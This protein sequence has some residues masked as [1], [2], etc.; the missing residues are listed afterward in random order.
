[1]SPL[2]RKLREYIKQKD[3]EL[4][5]IADSFWRI[6][7]PIHERQNRP[8]SN[9]NGAVHMAAVEDNIWRLL[10]T[11]TTENQANN[12]ESFSDFELFLL[13]CAACCHDF[14]KALKSALPKTLGFIHGEGSGDFVVENLEKLGLSEPQARAIQR[15][16]SIHDLK[17]VDFK[18]ELKKLSEKMASPYKPYNLQRLAV[19]LKAADIL[20]CDNSRISPLVLDA[21]K[22]EGMERKKYLARYCTHGWVSNGSRVEIQAEPRNLEEDDAVRECFNFMNENEWSAVTDEMRHYHFP[23]Q[24]KLHIPDEQRLLQEYLTSLV[25]ETQRIDMKGIYSRTGA[26]REAIHFPIEEIYTPLKTHKPS[27]EKEPRRDFGAM[28]E[29]KDE[30]VPLTDLLSDHRRLLIIGEPGGGKTTF[31]KFIA[32]VLAKDVL[33][34]TE[35]GRKQ[36][37]GMSLSMPPPVP[38]FMRLASLAEV[39]KESS[40]NVGGGAS[41]RCIEKAMEHIWGRGLVE[42]LQGP[43]SEGRCALLLDGLD[44][45]ADE[46]LRNQIVDVVNSTLEHWGENL[47]VLSSRPFGY[48]AVAGLEQMFMA[49]MDSFGEREILDFLD[50]WK[51]GLYQDSKDKKGIEYLNELRKAIMHSSSIRK[52]AHNPVMLTCLC[53]VHWNERK[54]PEGKAD[55][56]AAVLRW[57]L[58]ANEDKRKERGYTNTFA[59]E[60]FKVL[61]LAMTHHKEG[62]Q[63]I[64]DLAWAAD[65]LRKPFD[66]ILR[67]QDKDLVQRQGR[68][69]LEEEMLDSG[70]VEKQGVGQIRFWHLNFQEHFTARALVDRR[71]EDW[72]EIIEKKLYDRQ[73]TEVIDHFSGCLA[74]TGMYR[75]N[76]LVKKILDTRKQD[77][78]E[79]VARVVGVLGRILR[80]LAVYDNYQPPLS[81][82]WEDARNQVMEIFEI[83]GAQKVPVEQRI[84]AAEALGQGGDPRIDE[85]N[86]T[87]LPI[88]GMHDTLL[89]RYPVTVAEYRDFVDTGGYHN[90]LYWKEG[91][92]DRRKKEGWEAP[93]SWDDQLEYLN[94][95]VTRVSWYEAV[96]YCNWRTD[97]ISE[98]AVTPFRLPTS[99][100]WEKAVTNSNGAY[101]WGSEEPGPEL[102]NFNG[103][104]GV[105]TPVGI[106]PTGEAPG[107]HLDMAGNVWEWN[108][109][110]YSGRGSARVV[111]GGSWYDGAGFCRSAIRYGLDPDRRSPYVGFRLSRSVTL[112]P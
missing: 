77:E 24:L 19:L 87:L 6:S 27:M 102:L 34:E 97:Q 39:I 68:A 51:K 50:K 22:L 49:R 15:V 37:L 17:D 53:V 63:V 89:G 66:D 21:D 36:H 106:Y 55:L 104:V 26:G 57:L 8:D 105:P 61:A 60:C 11:S 41:W 62:K 65:R 56:L 10:Q 73:W 12:L 2:P 112:D 3:S 85:T 84:K 30:G 72:W 44:E 81:L 58:N 83:E 71:D 98:K 16:V 29:N 70:I 35:G 38:V 20:H 33:G 42:L 54:L 14:D 25:S 88:P 99:V 18:R 9:E 91:G 64:V 110:L 108:W 5:L 103:N 59:E 90:E 78:V 94:R 109:D 76:L 31:L 45:V 75:L 69:F 7:G 47:I 4:A 101:P 46:K 80:I 107:G 67:V 32:C 86:P 43:L 96:A 40:L 93:G 23:C 79:S 95:P 48:H 13:S 74:W 1:M 28:I 100:E 82:G 52:L 92:W 111:R